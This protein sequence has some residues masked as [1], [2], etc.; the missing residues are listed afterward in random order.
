MA[1]RLLGARSGLA[2]SGFLGGFVSSTAT[3]ASLGM[4]L[5]QGRGTVRSQVVQ[6]ATADG[7]EAVIAAGLAPGMQVVASGVHVLTPGQKVTVYK[8]KL[9]QTPADK[10]PAAINNDKAA[11]PAAVR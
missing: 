5:R 6:V 1:Q 9:D 2:V 11:A 10:A 4:E 7:N 8:P 3:V